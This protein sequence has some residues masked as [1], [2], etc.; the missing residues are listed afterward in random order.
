MIDQRTVPGAGM[1][2]AR[3]GVDVAGSPSGGSGGGPPSAD[4]EG[5]LCG[6]AEAA[7]LESRRSYEEVGAGVQLLQDRVAGLEELLQSYVA[8]ARAASEDHPRPGRP[9]EGT[10]GLRQ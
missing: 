9:P 6:G 7:L 3:L 5:H 10:A 1:H 8:L 4:D 2:A